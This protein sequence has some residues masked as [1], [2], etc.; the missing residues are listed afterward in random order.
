MAQPSF[1][2]WNSCRLLRVSKRES[3]VGSSSQREEVSRAYPRA[4]RK[5]EGEGGGLGDGEEEGGSHQSKSFTLREPERRR[6]RTHMP[7]WSW[8]G[9]R[10]SGGRT[11]TPTW[12]SSSSSK[13]R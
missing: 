6:E 11:K 9:M 12:K 2:A 5:L 3:V 7:G 13:H 4:R 10:A 1:P 8:R